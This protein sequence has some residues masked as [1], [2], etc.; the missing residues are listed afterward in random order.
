M[1]IGL[2]CTSCDST[3]GNISSPG[4]ACSTV[5]IVENQ[6]LTLSANGILVVNKPEGLTSFAVVNRVKRALNLRKAGH[7]GTLDP[8]A[9]GVLVIC[10][11][12][13]TRIADQLSVHDK[14]YRFTV[15]LGV[16]TDTLDRTGQITSV[17]DGEAPTQEELCSSLK[18]FMGNQ[19]QDVPKYAA[20]RV[21]GKHLYEW[22]RRGIEMSTPEREVEIH[23]LK[24]LAYEWPRATLEVHCSKGTYVRQLAADIGRVLGC[25]G[26]VLDLCRLASGPFGIGDAISINTLEEMGASGTWQRSL[27]AMSSALS[28]LPSVRIEDEGTLKRM[29]VGNLDSQWE[30]ENLRRFGRH[31]GAVRLISGDDVLEA[32]WW[33]NTTT[34]QQRRLRVFHS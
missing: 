23:G 8:F 12:Q 24:L 26:H 6:D 17:C 27:I 14:A 22:S 11:N 30:S 15:Q 19:V 32:L 20:V 9:T 5:A 34:D 10:I 28:H 21:Q 33:P 2:D 4:S 18:Q 3:R 13:A 29:R 31:G 25:G 1:R 16:E 7:C